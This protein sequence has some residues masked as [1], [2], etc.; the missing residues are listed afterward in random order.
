MDVVE[1]ASILRD[2]MLPLAGTFA[3]SNWERAFQY[4]EQ[5]LALLPRLL[6]TCKD[7]HDDVKNLARYAALRLALADFLQQRPRGVAPVGSSRRKRDMACIAEL[8]DSACS[9][10]CRNW[11]LQ[12]ELNETLR[13]APLGDLSVSELRELRG[14]L[15]QGW[16]ATSVAVPAGRKVQANQTLWIMP[17]NRAN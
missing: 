9:V 7:W 5:T 4:D 13:T 15:R 6:A 10:F 3:A 11:S 14:N 2:C 12:V 16:G 1:F 17:S 8:Y